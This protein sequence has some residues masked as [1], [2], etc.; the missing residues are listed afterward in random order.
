MVSAYSDGV[1]VLGDNGLRTN[2]NLSYKCIS[3]SK[4]SQDDWIMTLEFL[5]KRF[6]F[7]DFSKYKYDS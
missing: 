5:R 1:W 7:L 6:L 3:K 4:I 2:Q